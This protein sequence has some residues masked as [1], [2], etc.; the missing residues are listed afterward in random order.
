M[1]LPDNL[2]SL[3]R[4]WELHTGNRARDTGAVPKE[5]LWF[6][7]ERMKIWEQK[8]SGK[9]PPYTKDPI[10]SR[11]RFCNIFRE[12]DRQTIEIHTL[13]NPLRSYFPLWLLNMFYA[14]ML[15]RPETM[16]SVGLL[17]FEEKENK[18]VFF[19]C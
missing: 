1:E 2:K 12:L 13:L 8:I 19:V 16:R 9:K 4:H 6:I 7:G 17:S 5:I 10:L 18:T 11:Y 3:Y 15:A 14:R